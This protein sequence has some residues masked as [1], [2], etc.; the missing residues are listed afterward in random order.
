[1]PPFVTDRRSVLG[2]VNRSPASWLPLLAALLRSFAS[3]IP[4]VW[5]GPHIPNSQYPRSDVRRSWLAKQPTSS[6]LLPGRSV[7]ES[8]GDDAATGLSLRSRGSR[9]RLSTC[10]R[11]G[12]VKGSPSDDDS[13]SR[14]FLRDMVFYIVNERTQLREVTQRQMSFLYSAMILNS[15][16][17]W[18]S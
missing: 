9:A 13:G 6:P 12:N 11:S 14:W 3:L 5:V 16:I 18:F 1:V 10:P 4:A 7:F 2:G 8:S 17:R 15:N